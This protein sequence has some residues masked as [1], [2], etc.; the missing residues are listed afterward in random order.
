MMTLRRLMT[1]GGAL[2]VATLALFTS[3]GSAQAQPAASSSAE[4]SVIRGGA[5][6]IIMPSDTE[7]RGE[8]SAPQ[9]VTRFSDATLRGAIGQV[10]SGVGECVIEEGRFQTTVT[11]KDGLPQTI[12]R[13]DS[14]VRE[15]VQEFRW[16]PERVLLERRSWTLNVLQPAT[17]RTPERWEAQAWSVETTSWDDYGRPLERTFT[18]ASGQ[19]DR[20]ECT[21]L[22]FRG[23]HCTFGGPL[24]ATVKLT[25]RGEVEEVVW[26]SRGDKKVR[27]L[28]EATWRGDLVENLHVSRGMDVESQHYRYDATER[29]MRFRRVNQLPRGE[30]VVS[31]R[32]QRDERGNVHRVTRSC[33]GPCEG[34]RGTVTFRIRYDET[35]EN[36]FCGAWWDDGIEPGLKGW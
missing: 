23:G 14:G 16:N 22:G 28:L 3:M 13:S 8:R 17:R 2:T 32:L 7:K 24:D 15:E 35:L 25:Q 31:W 1:S 5:P 4:G 11:Y 6:P 30:R 9:R 18:Q 20:Y 10:P 26:E 19:L 27:G 33:E 12:R 36:T 29:L 34:M 21:W